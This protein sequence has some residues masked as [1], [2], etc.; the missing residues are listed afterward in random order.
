MPDIV[1]SGTAHFP[2]MPLNIQNCFTLTYGFDPNQQGSWSTTD[3]LALD[4][5][6]SKSCCYAAGGCRECTHIENLK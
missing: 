5:P 2:K 1:L 3:I 6:G 4:L